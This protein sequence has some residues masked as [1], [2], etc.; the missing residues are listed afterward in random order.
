MSI[1]EQFAALG[2]Y[3]AAG[4]YENPDRSVF[5]RLSRGLR[6]YW[7][8]CALPPYEGKPLYPSGKLDKSA[9]VIDSE[10]VL[11]TCTAFEWH[12]VKQTH[13]ADTDGV[14]LSYG[15]VGHFSGVTVVY[16]IGFKNFLDIFGVNHLLFLYLYFEPLILTESNILRKIHFHIIYGRRFGFGALGGRL[17]LGFGSRG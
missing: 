10:V 4:L 6:R 16:K 2:E 7:E 13:K 17:G 1:H 5:F 9:A 15:S 11:V 12:A 14:I 8:N 3:M